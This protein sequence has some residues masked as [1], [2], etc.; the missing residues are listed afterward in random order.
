MI[1][2]KKYQSIKNINN[3][4]K[5]INIVELRVFK[6]L[7]YKSESVTT[8]CSIQELEPPV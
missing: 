8:P 6:I 5:V 2:V 1:R 3:R 4:P 7:L